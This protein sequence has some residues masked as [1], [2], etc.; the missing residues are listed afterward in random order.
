MKSLMRNECKFFLF[1][2]AIDQKYVPYWNTS[3]KANWPYLQSENFDFETGEKSDLHL[4][5]SY[6][7]TNKTTQDKSWTIFCNI[8]LFLQMLKDN[9]AKLCGLY[10]VETFYN[11][12]ILDSS[13]VRFKLK[14]KDSSR[15]KVITLYSNA[16]HLTECNP[17]CPNG[18]E[19]ENNNIYMGVLAATGLVNNDHKGDFR[20]ITNKFI[21]YL[22]KVPLIFDKHVNDA[23]GFRVE[24]KCE[25]HDFKTMLND[26]E[27]PEYKFL[28]MI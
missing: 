8:N 28:E 12:S 25:S 13:G 7:I 3:D 24:V 19:F 10:K 27:S 21:N 20:T 9:C 6:T 26:T 18:P 5:F 16:K 17:E 2:Q 14:K 1:V 4:D 23:I 11:Y 15:L 22:G